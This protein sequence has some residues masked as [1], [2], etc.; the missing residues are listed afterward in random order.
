MG[1]ESE[2]A[3]LTGIGDMTETTIYVTTALSIVL[4]ILMNASIGM[5]WSLLNC[6]QILTHMILMAVF[7]PANSKFFIVLIVVILNFQI[8]PS[9]LINGF[10][11]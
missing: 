9:S 8:I 2:V 7:F 11:F 6:L 1:S 3:T 5:V 10:L 4:N